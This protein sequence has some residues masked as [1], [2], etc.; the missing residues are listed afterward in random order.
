M[1]AFQAQTTARRGSSVSVRRK[2]MT[3]SIL[4]YS[5]ATSP[6]LEQEGRAG[7]EDDIDELLGSAGEVTGGGSGTAGWNIDLE[8]GDGE[9]IEVW[10]ERI[11]RFLR[12]WGVP[13]DIELE[14]V[15]ESTGSDVV[16]KKRIRLS[17]T[18]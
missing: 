8:L 11:I 7:L 13:P 1:P 15:P 3:A 14:I 16:P 9:K 4:I 6:R 18:S 17:E 12:D 5:K 10:T 2:R